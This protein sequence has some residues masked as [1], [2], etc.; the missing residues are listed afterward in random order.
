MAVLTPETPTVPLSSPRHALVPPRRSRTAVLVAA[1]IGFAVAFVV[2]YLLFVRTE[3]GQRAED[4]VVRFAQHLPRS[5]VDWARPLAGIDGVEVFGAAGI[6]I[7]ALAVL[8]KRFALGVTALVLYLLPLAA[9]QLLKIYLL[10]RPDV[11]S[12]GAPHHNS[13]PSGHVSAATAVLL[14]LAVVLPARFRTWVLAVGAPGV[15]WVAAATV[16]L[17]WHRLSDTVGACLLVAAVVTAGA[18]V[19][20]ARRPD[21]GRIPPVLTAVALLGPVAVVLGGYAVLASATSVPA[22]SVAALVLAALSAVAVVLLAAGPLRRVNF[23]PSGARNRL[24]DAESR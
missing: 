11:G 1:A 10:D 18:A 5:T 6:V 14:A 20:S 21:G 3:A 9:A 23:D 22:R 8:R 13:F 4:G 2:A 7:V 12:S 24:H 19:V 15:A 17:S 16:A